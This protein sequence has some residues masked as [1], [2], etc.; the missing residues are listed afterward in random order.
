MIVA[1][2]S[3]SNR[4]LSQAIA[5]LPFVNLSQIGGYGILEVG[6]LTDGHKGKEGN[7]KG[8][9]GGA[10]PLRLLQMNDETT[11][12]CRWLGLLVEVSMAL[13]MSASKAIRGHNTLVSPA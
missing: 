13:E 1:F 10:K 6:S 8:L 4:L 9:S 12:R 11:K 2:V 3:F 7:W 5:G